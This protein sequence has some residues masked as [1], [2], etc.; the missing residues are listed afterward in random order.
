MFVFNE[1][2]WKSGLSDATSIFAM[3]KI[4]LRSSV[5]RPIKRKVPR[6]PWITCRCDVAPASSTS[7]GTPLLLKGR[8]FNERS[9]ARPR[10]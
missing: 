6:Q 10:A 5:T 1:T 9:A 3:Y 2:P 4:Q 8:Q 7:R